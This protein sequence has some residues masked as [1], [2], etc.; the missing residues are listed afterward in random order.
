VVQNRLRYGLLCE[1]WGWEEQH[2][3]TLFADS[4]QRADQL[5]LCIYFLDNNE[6]NKD[7]I[8]AYISNKLKNHRSPIV[9]DVIELDDFR[10]AI[11]DYWVANSFFKLHRHHCQSRLGVIENNSLEELEKSYSTNFPSPTNAYEYDFLVDSYDFEKTGKGFVETKDG[12]APRQFGSTGGQ[13]F[14]DILSLLNQ[15]C[16]NQAKILEVGC[17]V[18]AF[19]KTLIMN[20]MQHSYTGIDKSRKQIMRCRLNYPEGDFKV[21]DVCNLSLENCIYDFVFENNVIIFVTDPFRAIDEMCRVA[22]GYI[23]FTIHLLKEINGLYCYY[24]FSSIHEFDPEKGLISITPEQRRFFLQEGIKHRQIAEDKIQ[25][26]TVKIPC[27]VPH[28]GEFFDF[29]ERLIKKHSLSIE[30]ERK[31]EGDKEV[32]INPN[33][34]TQKIVND[35]CVVTKNDR[36]IKIKGINATY[37]L[38]KT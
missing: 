38:K 28:E 1:K 17:G 5:E 24:P 22:C 23:Y 6:S 4:F 13:N 15:Y 27:Y 19:F 7:I 33:K 20:R 11:C 18:G 10:S 2:W 9:V 32:F 3:F 34:T 21:D 12:L 16:N 35:D 36:L 37:L 31:N 14:D 25:A 29:F 26:F 8:E 30:R